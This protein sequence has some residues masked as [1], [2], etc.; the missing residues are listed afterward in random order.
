MFVEQLRSALAGCYET[1]RQF[2]MDHL[3]SLPPDLCDDLLHV[4]R[5]VN[6]VGPLRLQDFEDGATRFLRL[7]MNQRPQTIVH[8]VADTAING[9]TSA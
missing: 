5:W 7:V 9:S 8:L 6:L 4:F 3:A 1:R 2:T